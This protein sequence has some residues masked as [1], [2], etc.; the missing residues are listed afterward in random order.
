[1]PWMIAQSIEWFSVYDIAIARAL[2][3]PTPYF[4]PIDPNS[5]VTISIHA[6]YLGC[7]FRLHHEN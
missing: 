3:K 7:V 1:M 4:A 2:P 5:V 6:R